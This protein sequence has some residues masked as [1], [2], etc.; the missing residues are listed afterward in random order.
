MN[1]GTTTIDWLY[2]EQ[3]RV[4]QQW[5]ERDSNGFTW[6]ADQ[7][8]QRIEVLMRETDPVRGEA[9]LIRVRTELLDDLAL[10][11]RTLQGI[12]ALLM[13][14]ASMCGPVYDPATRGLS[15]SSI[16]RV[17][18]GIRGWM[19]PLIS[20]AAALQVAE[21]RVMGPQLEELTV[22]RFAISGHP[23]N[24]MRSKPDE[25]AEIIATVVAPSGQAPSRWSGKE[26][27]QAV[28]ASMMQPP[29]LGATYGETGLTVEFPYGEFS[30]L[31]QMQAD[32]QHP[33][34]GNGLLVRQSFPVDGLNEI[35]GIRLALKLN[36]EELGQNPAGYGFGSYCYRENTIHFCT[37]LPNAVYR[38]GMLTNLYYACAQRAR[39]MS[40]QFRHDDW[41]KLSQRQAPALSAFS[42]MIRKFSRKRP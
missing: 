2:R 4:D 42:R 27:E 30:S 37:F 25:M 21:A 14:F 19:A 41:S 5:S 28:K 6:W 39:R 22:G 9:F 23:S 32:E 18:E 16:V 3:L 38:E 40:M 7:N 24:G 17:H 8:A 13:P 31:C 29:S 20:M 15:L 11:D 12:G 34:Y 36:A 35:S 1:A 33:R 10:D 26:F